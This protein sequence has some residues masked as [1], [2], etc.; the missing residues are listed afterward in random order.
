MIAGFTNLRIS[1]LPSGSVKIAILAWL[2]AEVMAFSLAVKTFGLG[3]TLM[4]SIGLSVLGVAMLRRL[5][6]EAAQHLRRT[7]GT[8]RVGGDRIVDGSLTALGALLLII[9]GFVS[10]AV[11]LALSSPSIRQGLMA[12][13]VDSASA[14]PRKQMARREQPDVIDLSPDDWTVVERPKRH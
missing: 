6:V 11:G 5:G 3:L 14:M 8:G 13:F 12:R 2:I 1:R 7:I 4:I 10:D 9:P